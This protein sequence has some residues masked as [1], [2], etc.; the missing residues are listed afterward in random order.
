MNQNYHDHKVNRNQIVEGFKSE[1]CPVEVGN[2]P[3]SNTL[4]E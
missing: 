1:T 3:R 2:V 4:A